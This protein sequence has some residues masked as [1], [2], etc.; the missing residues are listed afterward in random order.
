MNIQGFINS[1]DDYDIYQ[2]L[3]KSKSDKDIRR[4]LKKHYNKM[5]KLEQRQKKL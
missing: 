1:F 4:V 2:K 3:K 5:F